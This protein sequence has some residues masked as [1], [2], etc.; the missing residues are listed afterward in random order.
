MIRFASLFVLASTLALCVVAHDGEDD[1]DVLEPTP[2]MEPSPGM[3]I[4]MPPFMAP[5]K[6]MSRPL[7]SAVNCACYLLVTRQITSAAMSTSF[8][9]CRNILGTNRAIFNLGTSCRRFISANQEIMTDRLSVAL[10]NH[11]RTCINPEAVDVVYTVAPPMETP[12]PS[13]ELLSRM[14][15]T[16]RFTNIVG[17]ACYLLFT[18][19]I[20]S[21]ARTSALMRCKDVVGP[22]KF[23]AK[24]A[25]K[26]RK[27]IAGRSGRIMIKRLQFQVN[28]N[29]KRCL[30]RDATQVTYGLPDAE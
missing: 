10:T 30:Q 8:M 22:N 1:G 28:V 13:V 12:E 26:C 23:I 2:D 20:T 16:R 4:D 25:N 29:V 11:A 15:M 6:C 14:C 17:C 3:M 5:R 9:R 21:V 7:T 24:G 18:N 27:F 19:Q